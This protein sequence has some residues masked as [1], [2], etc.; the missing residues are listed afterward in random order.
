MLQDKKT[1]SKKIQSHAVAQSP[2]PTAISQ[3]F[4]PQSLQLK[5]TEATP[6]AARSAITPFV[7]SDSPTQA[8]S[9]IL[10]FQLTQK[11]KQKR[12]KPAIQKKQD[13]DKIVQRKVLINGSEFKN[14]DV[15][16]TELLVKKSE[17]LTDEYKRNYKSQDEFIAH[18]KGEPVQCG[19]IPTLALWYR[20]PL[21][22]AYVSLRAKFFLLGELHHISPLRL[23]VEESNQQSA[24][25]LAEGG[26][27]SF[28][29]SPLVQTGK[30][31][32][33]LPTAADKPNTHLAELGL[34][35]ALYAFASKY[36]PLKGEK[37]LIRL[38]AP[39]NGHEITS[40]ERKVPPPGKMVSFP[41]VKDWDD[42]A[43]SNGPIYRNIDGRPYYIVKGSDGTTKGNVRKNIS[44]AN[45]YNHDTAT[46]KFLDSKEITEALEPDKETIADF[47]K[48]RKKEFK[49]EEYESAYNRV[50]NALKVRSEL[51]LKNV[52][53]G[54]EMVGR[55]EPKIQPGGADTKQSTDTEVAMDHRNTAM[56]GALEHASKEGYAMASFG[57]QHVIDI[58]AWYSLSG[59]ERPFDIITY[60]DFVQQ[61]YAL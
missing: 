49:E 42:R 37:S 23:I 11:K 17:W 18:A 61:Q 39:V 43:G 3:P 12:V 25:V 55:R 15:N 28:A 7:P 19:L 38:D 35:K 33:D 59:R 31:N 36:E 4:V 10:P 41:N 1:T 46:D 13:N 57:A 60:D 29:N 56:V 30:P 20:L 16:L 48:I 53:P 26:G 21:P 51:N 5:N 24:K 32:L 54:Q 52:Y 40:P 47:I 22:S 6:A 27:A 50:F 8:K 44:V 45:N 2:G 58:K 14:D 34:A 9:E